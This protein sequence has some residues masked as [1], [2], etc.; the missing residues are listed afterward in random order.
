MRRTGLQFV[1]LI[2]A[3]VLS[4]LLSTAALAQGESRARFVHVFP[5]APNVDVYVNDNVVAEDVA[6]GEA[7]DYVTVPTGD[8][9]VAATATGDSE[10][11]FSQT[12]TTGADP[13]TLVVSGDDGFVRYTDNVDPLELGEARLTAIHAINSGPTVDVILEDGRPVVPGLNYGVPFGTLDLPILK[14]PLNVVPAGED[15]ST[16]LFDE[17]VTLSPTMG[18]SYAV[19]VYGTVD[20]PEVLVLSSAVNPSPGDGLLQIVHDIPDVEPVDIYAGDNLISV[21]VA[22]ETMTEAFP[23]PAEDYELQVALTDTVDIL[24]STDVTVSEGR[25]TTAT[26][27]AAGGAPVIEFEIEASDVAVAEA[28]ATRTQRTRVLRLCRWNRR[29]SRPRKWSPRRRPLRT[30]PRSRR[31]PPLLPATSRQPA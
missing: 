21:G 23:I 25:T 8:I 7:S 5:D 4:L 19:V 18:T 12:V 14:L 11:L 6:Y 22:P 20:A 24:V 27:G 16:A 15:I 29:R 9:E 10:A 31:P 30:S 17:P 3:M 26:I 1:R 13:V 2:G 28:D